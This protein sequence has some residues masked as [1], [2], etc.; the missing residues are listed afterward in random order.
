MKAYQI[1][2]QHRMRIE[3]AGPIEH[4]MRIE[5]RFHVECRVR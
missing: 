5:H 1:E 3:Y 2:P 4:E